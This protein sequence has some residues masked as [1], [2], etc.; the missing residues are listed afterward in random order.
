[1]EDWAEIRRLHRAERV[2]IKQIAR[3]LGISKN[4]VK[5]ALASNEPPSYRRAP[6]G[7]LVDAVEPEVR[8]LLRVDAKTPAT[9]IA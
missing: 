5:S 9:V 2:P 3:E 6:K 1:M 4:T 7:S 8:K